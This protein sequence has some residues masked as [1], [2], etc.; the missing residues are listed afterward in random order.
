[1]D[2]HVVLQWHIDMGCDECVADEPINRF[3]ASAQAASMATAMEAARAP[4]PETPTAARQNPGSAAVAQSM[5]AASRGTK[6]SAAEV[7]SQLQISNAQHLAENAK[8]IEELRAAIEGF[9][10]C[11][12]K[13][14]ATNLVLSDGPVDARLMLVGEAP[15]AEEDRQGVPFVGPSG[16]LLNAMLDSIG[17]SREQ[18][19]ISNSVFWRPPGNRTPTTQ[20]TVVCRPFI[21]RLIEIVH[22]DVLVCIG[23]PSV[24]NLLG[25]TQGIS[26]LRGKWYT[27]QTPQMSA[28]INATALFHPAYLLRT[29]IKKRDAWHDLLMIKHKLSGK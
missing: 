26:R 10:G 20:E 24:H 25:Q 8:T 6:T 5:P 23:A 13:K 12:L 7:D 15:G 9:E 11:A 22:P 16:Q 27:F 28:P 1:M 17:V 4:T 29:P 19:L 3:E 14:T 21:E 18:V 2:S